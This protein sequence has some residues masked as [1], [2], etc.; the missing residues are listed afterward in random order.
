MAVH[1]SDVLVAI[2]ARFDDRVT[3]KV[4]AFA[5]QRR[6][7]P[8]RHRS[9]VDLEEHQGRRADRG[10]LPPRARASCVEAVREELQADA[11]PA[12][13]EARAPVGGADRGVEARLPAPLRVE[14]RRHQAAVRHAGDL[15]RSP[16]ARR[17]SSP[18]SA[19]TRCGRRSTTGSSTRACGAPPAG[20]GT[21]GYGLPTAMGVQAAQPGQAR[22]QHRRR[23]LLRR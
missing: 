19:S 2:G 13:R 21:M 16:T 15:Q 11:A 8:H 3:G 1:H 18:A 5:P 22:H 20:S 23:R 9:V 17:S 12:V 4:D 14:R 6:D 10:R 7:H